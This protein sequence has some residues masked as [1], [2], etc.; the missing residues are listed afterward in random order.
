MAANRSDLTTTPEPGKG[1]RIPVTDLELMSVALG[2][3]QP[4][5]DTEQSNVPGVMPDRGLLQAASAPALLGDAVALH[6]T[7][8][9]FVWIAHRLSLSDDLEACVAAAVEPDE[10]LE[11]RK[12]T[13]FN[14]AVADALT[15]KRGNFRPLSTNLLPLA[16]RTM[17]SMIASTNPRERKDGMNML[18]RSQGLFVDTVQTVDADSVN[19][20][21]SKLR[22]PVTVQI[23]DMEPRA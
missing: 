1:P 22:Q 5:P 17:Y 15:D 18:L 7:E 19:Q 9:Q 6:L 11:W 23:I 3:E 16:L 21:L 10:V 4:A 13:A 2:I 8:R 20:L 12:E 14:Q